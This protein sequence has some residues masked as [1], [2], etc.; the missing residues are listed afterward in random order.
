MLVFICSQVFMLVLICA[1]HV[2]FA[3]IPREPITTNFVTQSCLLLSKYLS[4]VTVVLRDSA[5]APIRSVH[6]LLST[7]HAN[8]HLSTD[9]NGTSDEPRFFLHLVPAI[10]YQKPQRIVF[11]RSNSYTGALLLAEPAK[12][13][14]RLIM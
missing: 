14:H 10:L 1:M 2:T 6:T 5:G 3:F 4:P 12:T 8:H 13:N 7:H 11:N 9:F